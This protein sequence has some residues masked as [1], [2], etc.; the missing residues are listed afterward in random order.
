MNELRNLN[1][2][3]MCKVITSKIVKSLSLIRLKI[4]EIPKTRKLKYLKKLV[5]L[6]SQT[7]SYFKIKLQKT[8]EIKASEMLS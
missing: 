3:I 5:I 6:H 1:R 7:L 8:T 4:H 2:Q